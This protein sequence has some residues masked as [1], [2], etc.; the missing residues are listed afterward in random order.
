LKMLLAAQEKSPNKPL[1]MQ[2]DPVHPGAVGQLMMAASLLKAL[3]AEPFVS[4][5]EIDATGKL[6]EAKGCVI[7][8]IAIKE[9]AVSFDR[10]DEKLPFPIPDDARAVLSFDPTVYEMSQYML[11]VS[12]LKEG[13]YALKVNGVQLGSPLPATAWAKGVNI[14]PLA[15]ENATKPN[16]ITNQAKAILNAVIAK[17]SIVGNFRG[18]S[19]RASADGAEGALKSQLADLSKKV[20]AAD[21]LIR[22]AAK[23][24]TLKF[25]LVAVK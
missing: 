2:G 24:S 5:A 14:T 3:H 15:Y 10:L 18:L 23:P 17:E 12:G 22:V 20:D 16:A 25:E 7:D 13:S 4:S 19:Q 9:G 11:A 21:A 1:S 8:H 6:V